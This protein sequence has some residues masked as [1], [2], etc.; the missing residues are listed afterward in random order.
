M[1][2]QSGPQLQFAP[3]LHVGISDTT[4]DSLTCGAVACFTVFLA[5]VFFAA[6]VFLTAGFFAVVVVFAVV[7]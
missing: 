5:A 7:F 1:H 3:H 2:L 6:T 4:I